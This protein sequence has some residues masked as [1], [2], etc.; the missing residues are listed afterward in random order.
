MEVNMKKEARL[1]ELT[2]KL[3]LMQIP[4][5]P[6][7]KENSMRKIKENNPKGYGLLMEYLQLEEEHGKKVCDVE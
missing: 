2:R 7:P 1:W 6:A 3:T 4:Y 5:H